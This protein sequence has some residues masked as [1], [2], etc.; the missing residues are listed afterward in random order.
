MIKFYLNGVLSY[1]MGDN[2]VAHPSEK[3]YNVIVS[4][5]LDGLL[6]VAMNIDQI[7]II[8]SRGIIAVIVDCG[9]TLE[10]STTIVDE[11]SEIEITESIGRITM[12]TTICMN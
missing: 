3:K 10:V 7:D 4:E 9:K 1:A 6:M 2:T 12:L 8:E 11:D 5:D